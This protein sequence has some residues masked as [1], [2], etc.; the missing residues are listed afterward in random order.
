MFVQSL[1]PCLSTSSPNVIFL[2]HHIY[3]PIHR[4]FQRPPFSTINNKEEGIGA[5]E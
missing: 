1:T 5:E 4:D 2:H 3:L